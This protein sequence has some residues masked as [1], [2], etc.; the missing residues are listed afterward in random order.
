[1]TLTQPAKPL[2]QKI[3]LL[4]GGA[5]FAYFA[6]LQFNDASQ[7]GNQDAWAWIGIYAVAS[8]LSLSSVL[9]FVFMPVLY[10]WAGF[11]LGALTF[12]LQDDQGN[13]Y[14]SRLDPSSYWN[15]DKT[16]M[17]QNSNE[18]GGLVILLVWAIALLY[19]NRTRGRRVDY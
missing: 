17:I 1:M 15:E 16:Q 13:F 19:F 6:Y 10:I 2:S 9:A 11:C 18:S 14:L 4:L 8:L 12:R 5:L 3:I 7:Y